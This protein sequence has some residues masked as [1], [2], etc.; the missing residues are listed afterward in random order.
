MK[1]HKTIVL[2]TLFLF[3]LIIISLQLLQEISK[4]LK[5]SFKKHY[6]N[7]P[8]D[9]DI[10]ESPI[11]IKKENSLILDTLKPNSSMVLAGAYVHINS[12]GFRDYEYTLKKPENTFRIAVLG[13]SFTFG[14]GILLEDT[15]VKQ[16]EKKLN[17]NSKKVYEV[18]NFGGNGGNTFLEAEYLNNTVLKFEPDLIIVGFFPNDA[19][20]EYISDEEY[21]LKNKETL[22]RKNLITDS[23]IYNSLMDRFNSIKKKV[24][25]KTNFDDEDYYF[26][27]LYEESKPGFVCFKEGLKRF[28]EISKE[29]NIEIVFVII[30]HVKRN[31]VYEFIYDKV[32]YLVNYY[33]LTQVNLYPT[34]EGYTHEDI[35]DKK[36]KHYN[37]LGNKIIADAIYNFLKKNHKEFN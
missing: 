19:E 6:V 14:Y 25:L 21:C 15:Y 5:K 35:I 7:N 27:S 8:N 2:V 36:S 31:P 17:N 23:V 11:R 10:N 37:Q 13:D 22:S 29:T 20:A 33:N 34:F 28:S 9:F 30:P 3:I 1:K 32:G 12:L 16:L 18:L 24:E 26:L 4:D